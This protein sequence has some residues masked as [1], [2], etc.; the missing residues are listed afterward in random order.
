VNGGEPFQVFAVYRIRQSPL[1]LFG[2]LRQSRPPQDGDDVLQD[3]LMG[4]SMVLSFRQPV[5]N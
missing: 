1:G 4:P 2:E 5:A 3:S